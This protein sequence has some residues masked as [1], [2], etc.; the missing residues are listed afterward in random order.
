MALTIA[1]EGKGVI[2][3]ADSL[4][5]DT[6]GLGTGTWHE[7]GG[8]GIALSGVSIQGGSGIAGSYSSKSG[9]QYFDIQSGSELDFTAGTGTED[10]Q[11]VYMWVQMP[12][13]SQLDTLANKGLAIR[14]G[15]STTDYREWVIAGNDGSNGWTGGWRCFVIDPTKAGT[16]TDTGTFDIANVRMFGVWIDTSSSGRGDNFFMDTI[17]VGSGLRITG[18]STTGWLDVMDYCNDFT[19]RAW[20]ML[21]EKDGVYYAYGNML[22][23]DAANQAA[24]VSF[25]D[26]G[27]VI[28]FATSEFWSTGTTWLTGIDIDLSGITIED[29]ASWTTTFTDGILVGSDNGR[30]GTLFIGNSLMNVSAD[31]HGGN[32]ADSASLIYG[33]T[34]KE[35]TGALVS[36]NDIGH[37]FYAASFVQNNQFDPVGAC[38]IRNCIFAETVDVDSALLWN[39]S[40]DIQNSAFIANTTGAAIEHPSAVGTPYSYTDM[41]FSGNTFDGLNSSGTNITVNNNGTSNAA[42]DEGANTITYISSVPI[43][44]TVQDEAKVPIENA[45]TSIYLVETPP[46]T[47]IMNKDT[48]ASGIATESFTD[49]P[50][51]QAIL[52]VRK[53]DSLDDPRYTAYSDIVTI[54]SNGFTRT[55]TLQ[56]QP[57]PI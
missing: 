11:H 30:S 44:I 32:H 3:N 40:I 35:F 18:T 19:N 53:S 1:I 31:L 20:G 57:L 33:T 5:A 41:V 9:W 22:I 49:T 36:G 2:A 37:K 7:L 55:V 14:L 52:K 51:V 28:K 39:E 10:G 56:E 8:G 50:P 45:Q 17:M 54:D 25:A 43:T 42:D 13:L 29:H 16:V 24:N 47:E 48:N 38:V 21:Q 15:S 46:R 12:A 34:I 4:T 6:G 26:S 23:G 27:R